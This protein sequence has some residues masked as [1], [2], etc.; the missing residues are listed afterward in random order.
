VTLFLKLSWP[1]PSNPLTRFE[2][3][4]PPFAAAVEA[5]VYT[6]MCSYNRVNGVYACENKEV[7]DHLY[8]T[9]GFK[10]WVLSDWTA[11]HSTADSLNAG[12]FQE[13]PFGIHFSEQAVSS[14]LEAGEVT[15]DTIDSGIL[16]MLTAM[17]DIGLFD[18]EPT[19]DRHAIVTSEEHSKLARE[20][21]A[22]SAVLLRNEP[23]NG[24]PLLPLTGKGMKCIAVIGDNSTV[25]GT[26][27]GH[28]TPAYTVNTA[29]GVK[30][31]LDA[32]GYTSVSVEYNDGQDLA[33]ATALAA[34]CDVVIVN[35]ATTCGEG[36]D[37][38][39]LALG[40]GQDELVTAI[41]TS[42]PRTIVS[43]VSPGPV[44]MPWSKQVPALI[45]SW[46]PGQEAG[47][48]LADVLFGI[49]N[50][51]ARLHVTLPNRDNEINFSEMQYPG[52]GQPPSA[53]Y[54]EGLLIGYRYYDA[55]EITPNFC[56][57]HG[58]SY[59]SF[60]YANMKVSLQ[61]ASTGGE[62]VLA[63]VSIDLTNTGYVTGAEIPQLYLS[64]PAQAKEPPKIL[65]GFQ[66]VELEASQQTTVQF[67]LTRR[68]LSVWDTSV[69]DWKVVA[70]EYV[71]Q[72]GASSC[73]LKSS[74][75]FLL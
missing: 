62:E 21:A 28:V 63:V 4:Y 5:G 56:F 47:N 51:S 55:H 61:P 60:E 65:K 57:G 15:M 40:D 32:A 44:L 13:M 29:Q 23:V 54:T 46:L 36:N 42:N 59:A 52:I 9:M 20:L 34:Q 38:P 69:H 7:L 26:G 1:P 35:V 43:V 48:G 14:A 11:T 16:R 12:N 33:S 41:V 66:K 6:V 53:F 68:D 50:P 17:Y 3:Y 37:R 2:L 71:A 22:K 19:G 72:V 8:Q 64:F 31:A 73:D 25:S 30:N 49:V 39:T 67:Q 10:G 70:G 18:H 45:E 74:S 75:S 58:L 27:S 24:A